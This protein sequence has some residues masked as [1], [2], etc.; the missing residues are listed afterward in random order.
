MVT[1]L[2]IAAPALGYRFWT[3][4]IGRRAWPVSASQQEAAPVPE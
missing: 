3:S 4:R 2:L 1:P